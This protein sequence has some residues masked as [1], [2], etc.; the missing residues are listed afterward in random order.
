[1]ARKRWP[2]SFIVFHDTVFMLHYSSHVENHQNVFI[3]S[4]TSSSK[5]SAVIS[6]EP[7]VEKSML[8][9]KLFIFLIFKKSTF[10]EKFEFLSDVWC[11]IIPAVMSLR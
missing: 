8:L 3:S 11:S 5:Q 2:I 10:F 6:I 7:V 1:M 4:D 9:K